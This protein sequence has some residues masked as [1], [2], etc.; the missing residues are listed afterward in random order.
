[1]IYP[2]GL[3]TAMQEMPIAKLKDFLCFSITIGGPLF[4]SC[5]YS[6][7]KFVDMIFWV[8][9]NNSG[10]HFCR[11]SDRVLFRKIGKLLFSS[12]SFSPSFFESHFFLKKKT[13]EFDS[14]RKL[15][16]LQISRYNKKIK[17]YDSNAYYGIQHNPKTWNQEKQ[18]KGL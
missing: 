17:I 4:Q 11:F 13:W 14:E 6:W 12:F 10:C 2:E 3:R 5:S 18:K 15:E 8:V 7:V 16:K 9:Q 1:M